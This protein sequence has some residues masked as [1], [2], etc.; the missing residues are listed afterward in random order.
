[1]IESLF[2]TSYEILS[3]ATVSDNSGG[4]TETI[5]VG[6]TIKGLLVPVS[7]FEA[8][9]FS[10][11]TAEITDRLYC[12]SGTTITFNSRVREKDTT[13]NYEVIDIRSSDLG[14]NSHK[15]IDLKRIITI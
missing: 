2:N 14:A 10:K 1:M 9:R 11:T 3:V 13:L 4:R 12:G 7:A 6:S 5:T 15:E 8:A